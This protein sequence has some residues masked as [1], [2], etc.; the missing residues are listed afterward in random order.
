MNG[1]RAEGDFTREDG[2]IEGKKFQVAG[3]YAI[4]DVFRPTV[5]THEYSQEPRTIHD[6]YR[7]LDWEIYIVGAEWRHTEE[8][9]IWCVW[10]RCD[11]GDVQREGFADINSEAVSSMQHTTV[12]HL[13]IVE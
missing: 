9:V 13:G 10:N 11:S 5:T 7:V 6:F 1:S 8:A 3:S 12:G 2:V 4:L